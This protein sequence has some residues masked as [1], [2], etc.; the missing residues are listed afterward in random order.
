MVSMKGELRYGSRDVPQSAIYLPEDFG[1]YYRS[2][3]P[4]AKDVQRQ[5]YP[6]HIT[7]VRTGLETPPDM[8][9]WGKY[10]GEIVEFTYAPI[11]VTDGVYYYLDVES[12]RIAEIRKELGLPR[13]RFG[14]NKKYHITIGNVKHQISKEQS[15]IPSQQDH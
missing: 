3:L 14:D 10:E 4:K 5:A 15:P 7:V 6:P 11:V 1:R 9:A 2:L 12:E 8:E 13:Y